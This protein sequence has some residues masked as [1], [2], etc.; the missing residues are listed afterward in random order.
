MPEGSL[1]ATILIATSWQ[2]LKRAKGGD[3]RTMITNCTIVIV[4]A[5]FFIE[6]NLNRIIRPLAKVSYSSIL[7]MAA[8]KLKRNPKR[9]RRLR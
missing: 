3:E 1:D 6:A 5:S 2:A 8:I 7:Q 9:L 4:F